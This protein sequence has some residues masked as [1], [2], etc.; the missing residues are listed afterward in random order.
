MF[1]RSSRPQLSRQLLMFFLAKRLPTITICCC[2]IS[3]HIPTT[4]CF[5]GNIFGYVEVQAFTNII[6]DIIKSMSARYSQICGIHFTGTVWVE[7][8]VSSY[9]I[10]NRLIGVLHDSIENYYYPFLSVQLDLYIFS[11]SILVAIWRYFRV[12]PCHA[13]ISTTLLKARYVCIMCMI[14]CPLLDLPGQID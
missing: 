11:E 12:N 14:Q 9:Q 7:L 1:C 6:I 4:L 10:H 2:C 8:W 5:H 3:N 13:P